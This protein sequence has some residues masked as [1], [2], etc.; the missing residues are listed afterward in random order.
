MTTPETPGLDSHTTG[1]AIQI[2]TGTIDVEGVLQSVQDPS[3]GAIDLFIGITRDHSHGKKVIALEYEAYT[4]M[5]LGQMREIAGEMRARWGVRK[6]AMVHRV[7]RLAIGEASVA[8]AV[9]SD[10]RMDAFEACRYAIDTLK[11]SVP[12]WKKEFFEDGEVWVGQEGQE[13][14]RTVGK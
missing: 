13:P 12:I 4:P 7:G 9:S 8:I 6:I 3:A 10:H 1:A 2:V 5:A 11:K 14:I